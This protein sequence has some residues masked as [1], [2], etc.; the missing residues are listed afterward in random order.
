[1]GSFV[2]PDIVDDGLIFAVDAGST[3]SYPGSGTTTTSLIGSNTGT[4][5]NGVGFSSV[6]VV[7][8]TLMAWMI[9]LL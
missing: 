1:M 9:I 8:G 4:L 5:T 2:G 7:I 6:M 3:R